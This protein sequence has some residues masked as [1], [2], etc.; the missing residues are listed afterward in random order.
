MLEIFKALGDES[1]L[2][3]VNLLMENTLCVCE[4]EV[5][6]DMN[7]SNVSRHLGKL[8]AAGII[9]SRKEAQWVRHVIEDAFISEHAQLYNYLVKKFSEEED[10]LK[11]R[12]RLRT[13]LDS[14]LTCQ[15]ITEDK[16]YVIEQLNHS[17]GTVKG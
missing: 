15:M 10:Y 13:Y 11:D 12:Q 1:R 9:V 14:S 16:I 4:I 17:I 8:K 5:M 3:I 7:Q 2:R 6:L